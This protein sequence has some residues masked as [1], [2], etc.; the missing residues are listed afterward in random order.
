MDA[1]AIVEKGI[2]KATILEE[3]SKTENETERKVILKQITDFETAK[4]II[5]AIEHQ[6]EIKSESKVKKK[7]KR[8]YEIHEL[9]TEIGVLKDKLTTLDFTESQITSAIYP[10]TLSID[11]K[12]NKLFKLLNNNKIGEK[13]SLYD[14]LISDFDK[15]FQQLEGILTDKSAFS[16][17]KNREA[18]K[19]RQQKIYE[20]EI[21][22]KINTIEFY[23][24]QNQL[25]EA[26]S[27]I[28]VLKYSIKPYDENR[29]RRLSKANEKL[30]EK[31]LLIFEK[32]QEELFKRQTEEAI[33][34]KK[35]QEQKLEEQKIAR[36]K[37]LAKQRVENDKKAE[38]ERKLKALLNK[39]ANWRDFQ[40]ILQENEINEFFHFTD[41]SN[42]KSIKQN[43]GLYS[44][45]YCDMNNIDISMPGGSLGSR[46]NDTANGKKDFVRVAI[47][48]EHPMLYVAKKDRRISNEV[49]LYINVEVAY[50]ENTEFSDKNAA[51]FS[52]YTPNIGK[53]LSYLENIR[54][55]VLK[56]A[57]RVKHYGLNEDEKPYN[58]AEVLIKT[59][60]PIEYITNINNYLNDSKY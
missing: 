30:K 47:N 21:N 46:Q 34:I 35:I 42:L 7:W 19:Q 40:K 8:L 31:E 37:E 2:N 5:E 48:K 53:D 59:W 1:V 36:E 54:F 29:L 43:G 60:I 15:N 28:E 6:P 9:E 44:W 55:D 25:N 10:D 16:R 45:F 17:H 33:K 20:N 32:K 4:N 14:V 24:N 3:A 49:W 57:E 18:E 23:I 38:K 12:V 22:K 52:S 27:L 50:F 39:K 11:N 26:K 41:I 51:A 58:Q 56:K 13:T